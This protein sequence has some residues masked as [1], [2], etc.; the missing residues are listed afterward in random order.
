MVTLSEQDLLE[1]LGYTATDRHPLEI[2]GYEYSTRG[3]GQFRRERPDL[4]SQACRLIEASLEEAG[5]FPRDPG[6]E[7]LAAGIY[8]ERR[9][10]G[11]ISL[12]RDVEVGIG[13]TARAHVD[14]VS[15]RDA[16]LE[17]LRRLGDPA[18]L[19]VPET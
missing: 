16:S 4:L 1:L 3:A 14:F 7:V 8:L 5:S 9:P 18:Y 6:A 17:L 15:P 19:P 13:Q 11:M 2:L 12:H 10:D